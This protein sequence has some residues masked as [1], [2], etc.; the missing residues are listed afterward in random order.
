[1]L[2]IIILKLNHFRKWDT[3]DGLINIICAFLSICS[4]VASIDTLI[5]CFLRRLNIFQCWLSQGHFDLQVP[6]F[7]MYP[8]QTYY[9]SHNCYLL[10]TSC[11]PDRLFCPLVLGFIK[12]HLCQAL[13]RW[14]DFILQQWK[15]LKIE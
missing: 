3:Y 13:E 12:C 6:A 5:P 7:I 15:Q 14:R 11:N 10:C 4:P 1:M 2:K 9:T 8:S